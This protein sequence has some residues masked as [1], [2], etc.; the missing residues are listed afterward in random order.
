[1]KCEECSVMLRNASQS[2]SSYSIFTSL[3]SMGHLV[4]VSSEVLKLVK[5]LYS[6]FVINKD[7]RSFCSY[8]YISQACRHFQ[9]SL[10]SSHSLNSESINDSHEIK[11]IKLIGGLF[12]KTM[13]FAY[14]KEKNNVMNKSRLGIRQRLNKIVL[15]QNV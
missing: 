14:A 4:S 11:L 7:K 10:F 6:L 2:K 8:L 13:C 12:F 3:V 15:F 9:G 5:Y 1:M